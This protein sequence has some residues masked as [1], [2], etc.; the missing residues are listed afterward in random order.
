MSEPNNKKRKIE[1]EI[2]PLDKCDVHKYSFEEISDVTLTYKTQRFECH[3]YPLVT[4][5]EYFR[6]LFTSDK[7]IKELDLSTVTENDDAYVNVY[8]TFIDLI[9]KKEFFVVKRITQQAPLEHID[10][11][12]KDL[13]LLLEVI[14]KYNCKNILS[15]INKQLVLLLKSSVFTGNSV[16]LTINSI[17]CL[18]TVIMK[19]H[20]EISLDFKVGL[21]NYIRDKYFDPAMVDALKGLPVEYILNILNH[22]MKVP[23]SKCSVVNTQ[24]L[25]R[26]QMLNNFYNTVAPKK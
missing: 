9:Y 4:E 22:V 19:P 15:R 24:P 26:V 12:Y 17:K 21:L 20:Y 2:V 18:I 14:C 3:R 5:S 8:K 1:Q 11:A 13:D 23:C 6:V 25:S 7:N 16:T 10:E